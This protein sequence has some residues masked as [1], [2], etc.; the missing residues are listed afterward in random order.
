GRP[1]DVRVEGPAEPLIGGDDHEP[2]APGGPPREQRMGVPLG[3][4]DQPGEELGHLVGV[5]SRR[6]HALLRA[7]QLGGGHQLHGLGDLLR[8]LDGSDPPLDVAKGRHARLVRY[9]ALMPRDATNSALASP[10]PLARASRRSSGS[11]LRLAMSGRSFGWRRSRKGWTN[12]SK[13]PTSSTGR[14]SSM[15]WVP[16]KIITTCFSTGSGAY[17]PCFRISTM[18]WPRA[19]CCWVALSR[20]EPN[21]AKAASSRYWARSSR[22]LPAT[23]RIARIWADP[24][25]RATDRPTWTAGRIPEKNRSDSR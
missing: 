15:P 4:A 10:M 9:A 21:W 17:W 3:A 25:T 24:P 12:S 11:S 5:G 19:S 6:D 22:S 13:A 16:A 23:W 18:R 2:L 14:S 1:E 8:R 20:S 7:A